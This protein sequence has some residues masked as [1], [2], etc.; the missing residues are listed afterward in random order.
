VTAALDVNALRVRSGFKATDR[1]HIDPGEGDL[2]IGKGARRLHEN[3]RQ[4]QRSLHH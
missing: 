4:E 1:A 2:D 3:G